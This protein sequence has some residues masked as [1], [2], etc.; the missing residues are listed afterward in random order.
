MKSYNFSERGQ[1]LVV[2]AL[3]AVVL[4]GF[5]ALAID[6]SAKFSDRRKAQNAADTAALAAALAKVNAL[7]DAE[8]DPT[9]STTPAECPPLSGTPSD[10]CAAL[11]TAGL[12][13]ASSNGYNNNLT[14]NAVEVHSPPISGYYIGNKSYVQVIITSHVKTTFMN[15]L[16]I[17]QTDNITQAVVYTREGGDLTDGSM[18]IS[19]DP[20]PDC[21]VGGSG[22][23]SVQVSGGATV[24]LDGGGIMMN[25]DEVCGFKIP[26][27]ADLNITGGAGINSVAVSPLDNIDADGCSFAPPLSENFDEDP[28]VIPDDVS[29]PDEP[30][31]CGMAPN[32]PYPFP[33]QIYGV[34][35][36]WHDQW[37]IYPGYYTE[38]PPASL[39]SAKSYIYMV[40]GVYCINLPANQDLSWSSVDAA[41][42]IGSTDPAKNQYAAYNPDGV[43][44]YLKRADG[45]SIN[46]NGPTY[47]DASTS[48]DLQGYLIVLE[49]T[50]TDHPTCTINGG[51]IIDMNGLIY[52]PYCN[53]II[54]GKAG[55]SADINAQL[56]GWD[57]R[58]NGTNEINFTYNPANEIKIKRRIGLMK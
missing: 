24:N 20:D 15:V 58:I 47:L 1:A 54:N 6:G 45:F 42:L 34:D 48:G 3:A 49:G 29:W 35:N 5:A 52:A 19:Y 9:I 28:I 33:T 51:T 36:K 32:T 38:F 17:N 16:G 10:V 11:L 37:L 41:A 13:R 55:E 53:F 46:G 31:E 26:N 23:Y 18:I 8:T 44:L 43:T 39:V 57:I 30:P 12:D 7:T 21:S 25:S 4:F 50:H 2:I 14:T 22:G 56:I 27:C 40:S